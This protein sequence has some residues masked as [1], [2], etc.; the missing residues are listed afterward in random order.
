MSRKVSKF[1][2]DQSDQGKLK[3]TYDNILFDS[4][5]E[6]DYYIYILDLKAKGKVVSIQLQPIYELFKGYIRKCDKKKILPICYYLDFKI[7]YADGSIQVIDVKGSPPKADCLIKRKMFEK[8]YPDLD[9]HW[10]SWSAKDGGWIEYDQLVKL[11]R[12][13]KK[14]KA[15][16][17]KVDK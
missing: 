6:K 2:I 14:V 13:R 4:E 10:V 5:M 3:R 9:F 17:K 15:K 11:R 16:A 1:N 8:I 12:E 7:T